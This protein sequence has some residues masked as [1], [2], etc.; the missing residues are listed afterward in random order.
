MTRK[1][2]SRLGLALVA[3]LAAAGLALPAS[4]GT[5]RAAGSADTGFAK[6]KT[7]DRVNLVAGQD[8]PVDSRSVTVHVDD[9]EQL[10]D[11]QTINVS[12]SGAHPTG[13]LVGDQN[14]ALAAQQE[15]PVVVMECRGIDSTSVP[16]SK[17]LSPQTCWTQTPAERFQSDYVFNY[18]PYRMDR[19]ATTADRAEKV[20][21]P[22][23]LPKA[24]AGSDAGV[25]H[26]IPFV[27]ANG[28]VYPG[29]SL[30]CAG[31]AP[32]A[33]NADESL[34]PGN[35]TY[36]ASDKTGAGS[37]KF[38]VQTVDSNA[39]MGCSDTVTCSLVIIPIM[40]ISCD[41]AGAQLPASEA[42]D[43]SLVPTIESEC[44]ATGKYAPGDYNYGTWESEDLS[45]SGEL[46]WSASNWRNR[47]SV[48]L[49]FAPSAGV[50]NLVSNGQPIYLYG[51]EALAQATEQ[52]APRFCLDPKLFK[53]QHVQTSEPQAK[54]LLRAGSVEAAVQAG[55]PDE[56]F[57]QPVVQAP[58]AVSGFAIA[59][60]V[61]DQ[62]GG[63][64]PDLKLTPRLLAKLL[65]E[66]YPS[67]PTMKSEDKALSGNPIDIGHDPEFRALNPGVVSLGYNLEPAA[68]LAIMSS[69]SDVLT[70]LTSY[71]NADPE[72]RAWLDGRPDPWGMV[73][74]PAYKGIKLPVSTW[75]LRDTFI[76]KGL[77]AGNPC[78][79]L[80]PTPW[81]PL[82][83]A[84]VSNPATISLNMQFD[85][86]NSQINCQ[87][88]GQQ[89]QKLVALGREN[90]GY[91]FILGLVSLADAER[92]QLNV[93]QLQ[94]HVS[95]G[96]GTALTDATGRTF[97]GPS[98]DG[99]RAAAAMLEPDKQLGTWPVPYAALRTR[100][101]GEQAYPG[102]LVLSLDV[103]TQGLPAA[104]AAHYA[105]LLRFA[106]GVGQQP[107]LDQGQLPVGYLPMT[108]A[109]HL[110]G[111]AA[112]TRTAA[113]AVEQQQ[114]VVP[115]VN[116]D[117]APT[118][119]PTPSVSPTPSTTS[120]AGTGT[121]GGEPSAAGSP[122]TAAAPST[123]SSSARPK[124][125]PSSS[126]S[127]SKIAV[128]LTGKTVGVRPGPA[129]LAFPALLVLV[130]LALV[131][132]VWNSGL[133]RR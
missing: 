58:V 90:P 43:P 120:E 9:T 112:Y 70:A 15:Y 111:L 32:E 101:A 94:T 72:A 121:T 2:P 16:A 57:P 13:G 51:S 93:A 37:I 11:R 44:A 59:Y 79:A 91:R 60:S 96:S 87:N 63:V 92:Y 73:V 69:D 125:S 109:N 67:N 34:Q 113:Q 52:W 6:T 88:A 75:P 47:I 84:P 53:F 95:S 81:L 110:A 97:V 62:S 48:P 74:N 33:A 61:D 12:W 25:Q 7:I 4:A 127:P 30:G 104:D 66:S 64:H 115:Y 35:T 49:T 10:R 29:G 14:S 23:P 28:T 68:T 129:A 131:A 18:P 22:S 21:E 19:Y 89:N 65:T 50:C 54:N 41:A 100:A 114:G 27:A 26:W 76:P 108:A 105:D 71:I 78:L 98:D 99:L 45:V 82:V 42:P 132:A 103:P 130:V 133:G 85:I 31:M 46:W 17:R 106:A 80:S 122:S 38:V 5:A 102:I 117:P 118:P 20:G 126:P 56:P 83:A 116:G 77:Q 128:V 107:G 86:A 39:S 124:P 123:S 3:L 24:C 40:G 1:L 55:P 119:T 8:V 36:G